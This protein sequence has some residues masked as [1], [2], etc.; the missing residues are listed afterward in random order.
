MLSRVLGTGSRF[1]TYGFMLY[2]FN[3]VQCFK[4]PA[5][6]DVASSSVAEQ[7]G[8]SGWTTSSPV[9]PYPGKP[10]ELLNEREF[11]DRFYFP[12]GISVQLVEGSA[13]STEKAENNAMYFSNEQFNARHR[14][15]LPSLFKQFLHYT[16]IPPTLIHPN[17]V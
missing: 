7:G 3:S 12:N 14:F 13:L 11:R 15:P 17:I 4:M 10:T 6:N 5:K 16:K 2:R 1:L 9:R 8:T